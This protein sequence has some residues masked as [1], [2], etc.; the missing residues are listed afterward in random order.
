MKNLNLF[1]MLIGA[2]FLN[3]CSN[4]VAE[5]I[6]YKINEPIFMNLDEF[7]ASVRVLPQPTE[8]KEQGKI[9]FYQ[10]FM[11]VSEPGKGIHIIDNR[12]PERPRNISFIELLG[13]VD[14]AIKGNTLYADSYIDM[15]WFDIT[16]PA[17]PKLQGRIENVFPETLP[18]PENQ[19]LIDDLKDMDKSKEIVIGWKVTE[20]TEQYVKNRDP[21]WNWGWSKD[22]ISSPN[23]NFGNIGGGGIGLTGSMSRFAIYKPYLY[24]V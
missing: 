2:I 10:G 21:W 12:K 23:S 5:T 15:V 1:L 24:P 20:R 17:D 9:A 11:Y 14:M 6:T 22:V 8:I 4:E 19:Y 16:S 7:R 3:S 13:N 18:I